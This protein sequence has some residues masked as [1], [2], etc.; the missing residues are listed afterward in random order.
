VWFAFL[1]PFLLVTKHL[2]NLARTF[3]NSCMNCLNVNK[4]SVPGLAI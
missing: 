3:D 2:P 4:N 1:T